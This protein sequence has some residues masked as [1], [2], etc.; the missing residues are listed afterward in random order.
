MLPDDKGLITEG[1]GFN[2]F[3]V[4][5]GVLTTPATKVLEGITRVTVLDIA[6]ANSASRR[7]PGT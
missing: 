5:D 4:R 7:R 2:I 3:V 1:A 6:R